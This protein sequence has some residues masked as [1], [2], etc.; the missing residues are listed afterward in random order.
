MSNTVHIMID[1]ETL[2][3]TPDAT[4]LD[5]GVAA[6]GT[7][8]G[9]V[10]TS[11]SWQPSIEKQKERKIE[12]STLL[13]WHEEE[14]R[15]RLL[16][17]YLVSDEGKGNLIQCVAALGDFILNAV[18]GN[19]D[20]LIWTKGSMDIPILDNVCRR[21]TGFDFIRQFGLNFRA[22]RD[23]RTILDIGHRKGIVT[24]NASQPSNAGHR[25]EQ[26]AIQQLQDLMVI[27]KEVVM[28]EVVGD[29]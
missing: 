22:L 2:G 13:W 27:W 24:T 28:K 17:A 1:L 10:Y 6:Q 16:D 9:E 7:A 29:E 15:S 11:R 3:V 8:V 20:Y 21:V 19:T 23:F 26:D 4:V 25:A 18:L 12:H 14:L 5:I